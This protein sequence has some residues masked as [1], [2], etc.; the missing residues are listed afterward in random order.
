MKNILYL[1][2]CIILLNACH[3]DDAVVK[4]D[5]PNHDSTLL[6]GETKGMNITVYNQSLSGNMKFDLNADGLNDLKLVNI[7]WH[8]PG[9]GVHYPKAIVPLH[10][11]LLIMGDYFNDSIFI[12]PTQTFVT[13]INPIEI[14]NRRI[15]SCSRKTPNDSVY[16]N[17][18]NNI[19][20]RNCN[21]LAKLNL[22]NVFSNDSLP[23][24][25]DNYYSSLTTYSPNMDT[26]YVWENI[27]LTDCR[28]MTQNE[29]FYVG[30]VLEDNLRKRLGWLKL[31]YTA[32]NQFLLIET[33]IQR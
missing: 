21:A 9:L 7:E 10:K 17:N 11:Q 26:L 28:A 19:H 3:K 18:I 32:P 27:W 8:S 16:A 12:H 29:P 31:T 15:L 6:F 33:A 13:N 5:A 20:V 25:A 24:E 30:F 14:R 1:S 22:S 4:T 2:F 23:M